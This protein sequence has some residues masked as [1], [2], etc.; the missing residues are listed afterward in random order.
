MSQKRRRHQPSRTSPRAAGSARP[1]VSACMIVKDEEAN[2]ARCLRSLQGK[3][4]EIIVVDTGSSDRSAEIA[5]EHGAKV[6]S[7]PWRD[8]FAAAR[9]ESIGHASGDWLFWTDADEELFEETP[10][11]LRE[12]CRRA[13]QPE[14]WLVS[15]RNLSS[16]AGEVSTVIRQWRLFRNHIGLSFHG[17]IHEHLRH[18]N[19]STLAYLLFQDDVWIRHWGYL[20]EPDLMKRKRARN[21]RL[22]GLAVE[23]SPD[24]PFVH[25]NV[26]KQHVAHYEFEQGL[27][28]LVRGIELWVAQGRSSHAYVGNMFALAINAAVELRQNARAVELEA[29]LPA[30]AIS[31]DHLFQAGV[32]WW[33]LGHREQALER[34]NRA[35]QDP[36]MREGIECDP[37]SCTWRPL[38]ALAQF[39]MES[40]E[41]ELAYE[42]AQQ[43]HAYGPT[44]PNILYALALVTARLKRYDESVEW[45]R[46]LLS[47]EAYEG[48][49]MQARRMLLNIG[50]GTGNHQLALEAFSGAIEGIGETEALLIQAG[51]HAAL[52]NFQAQ[53][54]ILDAGCQ[55]L[56]EDTS[57]R[58]AL[59][60]LLDEQGHTAKAMEVLGAGLDQPDPPPVLY[61][62]LAKVLT[63]LGRFDD[64]A[65]AMHVHETLSASI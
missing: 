48:Y 53:Y 32:A 56:P 1:V 43:A 8:D 3:V 17:R 34:L 38:S 60:K 59:A 13:E 4:D 39:Y 35:W 49:K 58:L 21:E 50:Q 9:N 61:A 7:F 65:N 52:G 33:R 46:K 64:A 22:L 23:E 16:E 47:V 36:A 31:A 51:A 57:I 12:L 40:G 25:Y 41:L 30:D 29:L 44:L 18:A 54:E 28:A 55:R 63:K 14:G 42:R 10:G 37:S 20:P 19:G 5:Q 62:D 6:F 26:G 45:A 11:A 24:D 2:L 15:C 27:P